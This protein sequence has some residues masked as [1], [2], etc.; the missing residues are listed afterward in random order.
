MQFY[1]AIDGK[2][3]G[4]FSVY[5]VTEMLRDDE[6]TRD[7]LGWQQGQEKWLPLHEIPALASMIESLEREKE[8]DEPERGSLPEPMAPKEKAVHGG[9]ASPSPAAVANARRKAVPDPQVR[10]FVRFWARTFDYMI[11]WMVVWNFF[12]MPQ[13]PGGYRS[14]KWRAIRIS[15]SARKRSSRQGPSS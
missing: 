5:R 13:I 2:E 8:P 9:S 12:E 4:P 11:V 15:I 10:P 1:I 7:S 14:G 6:V 3:E